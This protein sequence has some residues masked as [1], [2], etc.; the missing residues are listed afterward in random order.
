M[1]VLIAGFKVKALALNKQAF[2]T[3]RISKHLTLNLLGY[4]PHEDICPL[5][6]LY[7]RNTATFKLILCLFLCLTVFLYI[8]AHPN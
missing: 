3:F 1:V 7:H 4:L 5:V 6:L 2:C 8:L